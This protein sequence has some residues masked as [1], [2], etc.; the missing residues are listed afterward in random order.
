MTMSQQRFPCRDLD[1]EGK[2]LGVATGLGL[3][4]E[5]LCRDRVFMSRQCLAKTKG[6]HVATRCGQDQGALCCDNEICVVT[7]FS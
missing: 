1:G 4:Q 3:R 5:I 2:R 6:F 7:E